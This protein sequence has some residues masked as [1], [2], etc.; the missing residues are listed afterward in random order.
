MV[1]ITAA[2]QV[3]NVPSHIWTWSSSNWTSQNQIPIYHCSKIRRQC[4]KFGIYIQT[5][6]KSPNFAH[7]SSQSLKPQNP[8]PPRTLFAPI[9]PCLSSRRPV[10][11]NWKLVV[12]PWLWSIGICA[13]RAVAISIH[14]AAQRLSS[15]PTSPSLIPLINRRT[16]HPNHSHGSSTHFDYLPTHSNFTLPSFGQAGEFDVSMQVKSPLVD[17]LR[18]RSIFLAV[19]V[20]PEYVQHG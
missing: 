18:S 2:F 12:P 4:F 7:H 10:C 17:R 3:L 13:I 1:L 9:P 14:P 6:S 5:E 16:S 15:C 19:R 11:T 20:L 8:F